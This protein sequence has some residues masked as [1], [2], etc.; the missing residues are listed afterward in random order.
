[1]GAA[2]LDLKD[3]TI[4]LSRATDAI[5]EPKEAYELA[6]QVNFV[7]FP[8]GA[9]VNKD[10]IYMYYGGGDSV[11]DVASISIQKLLNALT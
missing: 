11:I 4:V 6:G 9:V 10:C 7:V 3:P 1:M 5:F 8:C 2:L